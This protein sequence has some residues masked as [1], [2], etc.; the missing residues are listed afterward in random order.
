MGKVVM[1]RKTPRCDI[2]WPV[3]H[4]RYIMIWR[5]KRKHRMD[6]AYFVYAQ[7]RMRASPLTLALYESIP[8]LFCEL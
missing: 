5:S 7:L 8:A 3:F 6:G 4:T 2:S 1:I